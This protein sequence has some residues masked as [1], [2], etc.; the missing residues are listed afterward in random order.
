MSSTSSVSTAVV[1]PSPPDLTMKDLLSQLRADAN[2]KEVQSAATYS[3]MW[4]A[5]QFGHVCIGI[6]ADFLATCIAG[7]AI[8]GFRAL[9]GGAGLLGIVSAAL[10]APYTAGRPTGLVLAL[11]GVLLW[12]ARAYRKAVMEATGTFPL[13]KNLLR[14]NALIAAAYMVLGAVFGFALHT[15]VLPAVLT[16]IVVAVVAVGLA[17]PWFRQ[18]IVWQKGAMPYLSRLAD[19]A[20]T[21]GAEDAQALQ[22]LIEEGAPPKTPPCQI[23]IGGPI[24]SGRTPMA[25]GIGTE[26]AFRKCKVRYLSF[27]MLLEFAASASGHFYPDDTGPTTI[28]YW[29]WSEAQVVIIDDVGPLIATRQPAQQAN[30][31]RFSAILKNDLK[32]IAGVLA[33]CHTVWVIG[34]LRPSD[35]GGTLPDTLDDFAKAIREYCSGKRPAVVVELGTPPIAAVPSGKPIAAAVRSVRH[36]GTHQDS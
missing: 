22:S 3:H 14:A 27:D 32:S 1:R 4:L 5:N 7:W 10:D 8:H 34:D 36:V 15:S 26:F 21:I 25:A 2:G 12:E 20:P 28:G 30:L 13:D 23:V 31:A 29:P 11:V 16:T 24:G 17:P 19:T 6:L 33:Q 18:K 9:Q 35:E